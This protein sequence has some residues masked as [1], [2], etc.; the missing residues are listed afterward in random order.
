MEALTKD[1]KNIQWNI[2]HQP[3][4]VFEVQGFQF[5][6]GHGDNLRGGD[7]A[8]GIPAHSI[9]RKLSSSM[10]LNAK[11]GRPLVNYFCFGHLHKP[12]QIPHTLGE[13]IVN[14]GFPGVDG[15]GLAEGFQSYWPS[16]KLFLVHPKFGRAAC[17]DLR[18]DVAPD[19]EKPYY[20]LPETG[21]I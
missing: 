8:L 20:E 13:V 18:L 14:G 7:K 5:H 21:I 6:C 19:G 3:F 2:N 9:G 16:Q 10:G 15:F 17:Y 1:I 4:A 12:I 11:I